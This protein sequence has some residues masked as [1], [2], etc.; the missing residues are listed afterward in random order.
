MYTK[1]LYTNG[2]KIVC[3]HSHMSGLVMMSY[4]IPTTLEK[5]LDAG[6]D[7]IQNTHYIGGSGLMPVM[8]SVN[9]LL[10]SVVT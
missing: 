6:N 9:I 7:V 3:V 1:Q 2:I 5:W 8:M 10:C 4:K